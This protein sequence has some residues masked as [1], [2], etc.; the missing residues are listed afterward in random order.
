MRVLWNP[1]TKE[2]DC[3]AEQV[4]QR[5]L[6]WEALETALCR[7]YV[8]FDNI[9]EQYLPD[10]VSMPRIHNPENPRTDAYA[11]RGYGDD[12]LSK[13]DHLLGIVED[14]LAVAAQDPGMKDRCFR[15]IRRELIL[16]KFGLF[17]EETR[18]Q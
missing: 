10:R 14:G 16:S 12:L 6:D 17:E 11:P 3:G 8:I 5:A 18:V 4:H 13:V 9:A 1:Y 2:K 15:Q 7:T